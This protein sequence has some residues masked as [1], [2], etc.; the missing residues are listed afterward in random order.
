V[1]VRTAG[2]GLGL[3]AGCGLFEDVIGIAGTRGI[4]LV[5]K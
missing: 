3:A 2:P 1:F 4:R 5:I